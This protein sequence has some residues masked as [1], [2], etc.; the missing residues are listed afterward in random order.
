MRMRR[1][2]G[3]GYP[4]AAHENPTLATPGDVAYAIDT[5]RSRAQRTSRLT[6]WPGT[7]PICKTGQPEVFHAFR[8]FR[9]VRNAVEDLLFYRC[10]Q[11]DISHRKPANHSLYSL[12]LS[13]SICVNSDLC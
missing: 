8:A 7:S 3:I 10:P 1:Y 6:S 4:Y 5:L 9:N 12:L 13:R 11:K 2:I